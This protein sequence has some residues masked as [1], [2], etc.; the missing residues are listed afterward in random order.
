MPTLQ[1]R[2]QNESSSR[3]LTIRRRSPPSYPGRPASFTVQIFKERMFGEAARACIGPHPS[4][5]TNHRRP[6]PARWGRPYDY[7]TVHRV[8]CRQD[9]SPTNA[10]TPTLLQT[11]ARHPPE[12]IRWLEGHVPRPQKSSGGPACSTGRSLP[13][14]VRSPPGADMFSLPIRGRDATNVRAIAPTP[15]RKPRRTRKINFGK[16]R[17][18]YSVFASNCAHKRFAHPVAPAPHGRMNPALSASHIASTRFISISFTWKW[19]SLSRASITRATSTPSG[20]S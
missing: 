3:P 19:L 9:D 6:R 15:S 5:I 11:R 8:C 13:V 2:Y 14:T 10:E 18:F 20:F 1:N 4:H 16:F 12:V 17:N 7:V